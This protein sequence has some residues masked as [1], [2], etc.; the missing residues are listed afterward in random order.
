MSITPELN[1]THYNTTLDYLFP[2]LLERGYDIAQGDTLSVMDKMPANSVQCVI[3]SPPYYGLRSYL[4]QDHADKV[5]EIGGGTV[6]QY[7]D[8]M[9]EFGRKVFRVLRQ[10]GTLWLNIGDTFARHAEGKFKAKDLIGIPWSLAFRLRDECGF[11]LRSEVIWEKPNP[12]PESATDRPTKAHEQIFLF[13]KNEKYYYD[14]DAIR[15]VAVT[16]PHSHGC[17]K[18]ATQFHSI[19]SGAAD[20]AFREPDRIWAADGKKNKRSVWTVNVSPYK[21]AHMATFPPALI[22]PCVMAGCPVGGLVLDPFAGASTTG[23]VS[24][25][26]GR[27]FVGI[28]LNPEY[29]T[30][31]EGRLAQF[32]SGTPISPELSAEVS[33]PGQG[34]QIPS[35]SGTSNDRLAFLFEDDTTSPNEGP[36][37][38]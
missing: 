6:A 37:R 20:A 5:L 28:E 12:M 36:T 27:R 35:I 7:L 17:S 32:G 30:V 23:V 33:D 11:Y 24:L 19:R 38:P 29:C 13:T 25:A 15:E 26:N 8:A 16:K 4:P 1:P 3:T 21:G 10:D 9:M 2:R 34:G 14:A 22:E 31:S 18:Q